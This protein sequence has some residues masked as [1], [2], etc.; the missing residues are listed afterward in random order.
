MLRGAQAAAIILKDLPCPQRK[1]L[2]SPKSDP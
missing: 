2:L 1:S